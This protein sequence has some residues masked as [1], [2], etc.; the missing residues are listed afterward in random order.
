MSPYHFQRVFSR[1][2]GENCI[3]MVRRLRLERA[4][5]QLQADSD[6]ISDVAFRAGFNSLEAFSRAF[7]TAFA[8]SATEFRDAG[9]LGYCL[10][11]PNGAHFDRGQTPAFSPI[12]MKGQGVPFTLEVVPRMLVAG[13]RHYGASY[14][15]AKTAISFGE[16]LK[17][18]GHDIVQI[19]MITY[20]PKLG[21]DTPV[22]EIAA[23]VAT[24]EDLL[25]GGG[26]ERA[27][28]GGGLYL[29]VSHDG[30]GLQ[31]G[32][33]WFRVWAEALPACGRALRAAPCFQIH[34]FGLFEGEPSR[35]VTTINIPVHEQN[36]IFGQVA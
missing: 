29:L 21:P 3:Q 26:Y 36:R 27:A 2:A 1:V 24:S 12:S 34:R 28:L 5:Y 33:F 10:P 4:A 22:S 11:T 23:Y 30:T 32:D 6:S 17:G 31:L 7:R 19:P 15:I 8:T 18:M 16:E 35:F 14:L 25:P 20:A 9:W 13:R